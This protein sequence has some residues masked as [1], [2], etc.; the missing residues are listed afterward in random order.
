MIYFLLFSRSE[1]LSSNTSKGGILALAPLSN[2]ELSYKLFI[3]PTASD[4]ERSSA[5]Y[6]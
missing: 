2:A 6:Y 5:A 3:S 1:I 4:S